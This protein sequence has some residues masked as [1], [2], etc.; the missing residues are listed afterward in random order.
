AVRGRLEDGL[1]VVEL[2]PER[3]PEPRT[4][5]GGPQVA[6]LLVEPAPRVVQ[7]RLVELTA[8][9][10]A[11]DLFLLLMVGR[12]RAE[13]LRVTELVRALDQLAALLLLLLLL[14]R[15]GRLAVVDARPLEVCRH[16]ADQRDAAVVEA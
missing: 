3:V 11:L 12:T 13:A 9:A 8:R 14:R 4:L 5:T 16:V 6:H 7:H 10:H 2:A 15:L 1:Q